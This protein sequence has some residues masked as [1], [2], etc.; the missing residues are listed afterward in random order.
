MTKPNR[1]FLFVTPPVHT[2]PTSQTAY[3]LYSPQDL[4]LLY[5][6]ADPLPSPSTAG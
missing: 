4:T 6:S 1:A 5:V 3:L 2:Q